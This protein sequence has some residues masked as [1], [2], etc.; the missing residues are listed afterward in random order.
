[1]MTPE[2]SPDRFADLVLRSGNCKVYYADT[3]TPGGVSYELF[4]MGYDGACPDC[5]SVDVKDQG[6]YDKCLSCGTR[7]TLEYVEAKIISSG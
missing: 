3:S 1:M 7:I 2:Y 5:G 4:G 6:S